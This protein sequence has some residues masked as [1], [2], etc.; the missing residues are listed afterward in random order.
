MRNELNVN[1]PRSIL[2]GDD[3]RSRP[4]RYDFDGSLKVGVVPQRQ[5]GNSCGTTSLAMCLSKI[6]GRPVGQHDI[7]AEI[8]LLDTFT[9]AEN[10]VSSARSHGVEASMVNNLTQKEVIDAI[11][12]GRPVVFLSDITPSAMD[13]A[14][15]W[16]VIDGVSWNAEGELV[17]DI[18]DPWGH[19]Y[20]QTWTELGSEW[21]DIRACGLNSGYNRFGIVL[22]RSPNDKSLPP[23]RTAGIS[24]TNAATDAVQDLANRAAEIGDGDFTAVFKGTA[25]L[26][27][28]FFSMI[29][30]WPIQFVTN[31]F[32]PN[33]GDGKDAK[34]PIDGSDPMLLSDATPQAGWYDPHT[35]IVKKAQLVNA[36]L[37]VAT[38]GALESPKH[39]RQT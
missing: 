8:R 12:R 5:T 37:N 26:F 4:P 22:G 11:Q 24:A 39:N 20:T 14:L 23:G 13:L 7:D 33:P 10:I 19:S 17:L 18:Q 9:S 29:F 34:I 38:L 21:N 30:M 16:R 1:A 3:L 6:L 32:A 35:Q 25:S 15:H 36:S 2:L 28:L 27:K 31:L